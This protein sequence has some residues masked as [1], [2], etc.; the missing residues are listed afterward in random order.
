MKVR[1]L[2]GSVEPAR[3][4]S[5]R[6]DAFWRCGNSCLFASAIDQECD[7][8][9]EHAPQSVKSTTKQQFAFAWKIEPVDPSGDV[10]AGFR[11]PGWS[12]AVGHRTGSAAVAR[13][14]PRRPRRQARVIDRLWTSREAI[15]KSSPL[16][17]DVFLGIFYDIVGHEINRPF[18]FDSSE[19]GGRIDPTELS[20]GRSS[21]RLPM[22]ATISGDSS[23]LFS[24]LNVRSHR[25]SG[26][27]Q[28]RYPL[29]HYP[30]SILCG[31]AT[32][33]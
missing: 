26:P 25:R 19:T 2:P 5:C 16:E 28:R 1:N 9:N 18:T 24:A 17:S 23:P 29:S 30:L 32:E 3:A 20:H 31:L 4:R 13:C 7:D 8:A 21:G 11:S 27:F 12:A 33:C 22:R 6:L 10:F 14:T 15:S